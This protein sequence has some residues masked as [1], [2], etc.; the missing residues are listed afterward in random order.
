MARG[1]VKNSA[2]GSLGEVRYSPLS[3]AQ[4]QA[5]NGPG[6]VLYD[7][8]SISGSA[9]HAFDGTT[10]FATEDHRGLYPR[11]KLNGRVFAPVLTE[12]AIGTYEDDA[13]HLHTHRTTLHADAVGN[14]TNGE[15][16]DN[17]ASGSSGTSN[18]TSSGM[19]TGRALST[20]TRVKSIILNAFVKINN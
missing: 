12:L 1:A 7:N 17:D 20:E 15:C 3:E 4:F 16:M 13:V 5:E 10:S 2:N 6:W 14:D 11:A 18:W 19:F 8:R 9:L